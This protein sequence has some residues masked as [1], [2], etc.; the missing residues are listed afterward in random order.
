M[1]IVENI[2]MKCVEHSNRI[3]S[4]HFIMQHCLRFYMKQTMSLC[5]NLWFTKLHKTKY[6]IEDGRICR[7]RSWK[8][9]A[10]ATEKVKFR[11]IYCKINYIEIGKSVLSLFVCVCV[12]H[13]VSPLSTQFS[14]CEWVCAW[15]LLNWESSVC[16]CVRLFVFTPM[17][18]HYLI[19][20]LDILCAI[21][22]AVRAICVTPEFVS[23]LTECIY[24]ML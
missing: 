23:F 24:G 19:R 14:V 3:H 5:F 11:E 8:C 4:C 21:V 12:F 22:V 18:T 9:H 2:Y 20:S 1:F 10:M 7:A 13:R 17:V 6:Y 15:E 16:L